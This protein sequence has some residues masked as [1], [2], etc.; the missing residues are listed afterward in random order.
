MAAAAS[1]GGSQVGA[2][3]GRQI[4]GGAG[5]RPDRQPVHE[6]YDAV[7]DLILVEDNLARQAY[8]LVKLTYAIQDARCEC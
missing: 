2:G 8:A 5:A 4:G 6:R 7:V 1:G 3:S